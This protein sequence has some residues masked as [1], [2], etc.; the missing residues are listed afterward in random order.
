MIYNSKQVDSL[1]FTLD[2]TNPEIKGGELGPKKKKIQ[3][4]SEAR[5][6][7]RILVTVYLTK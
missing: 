6:Q 7:G 4:S 5:N 1:L 3:K 2:L